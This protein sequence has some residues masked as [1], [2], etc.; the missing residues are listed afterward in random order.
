MKWYREFIL[1]APEELNGFFAF[2]TVPPGPPFPEHLH[3]HK[4]CGVLW[5]YSGDLANA[6]ELFAP[7][8]ELKP[9]LYGVHDMPFP[10]LNSAFDALYPPRPPVVLE[11]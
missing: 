7:V 1:S 2:L 10:A 3:L 9:D 8:R 6:E 11:G 5:C 4:M